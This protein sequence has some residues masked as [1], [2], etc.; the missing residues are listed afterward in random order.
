MQS[1]SSKVS[2][3]GISFIDATIKFQC[4]K[5]VVGGKSR[6]RFYGTMDL[7]TNFLHGASSLTRPPIFA[8]GIDHDDKL[9][10]NLISK[11]KSKHGWL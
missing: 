1:K 11:C 6:G 4:W 5:E 7:A 3:S 9:V 10:E 8:C 2:T